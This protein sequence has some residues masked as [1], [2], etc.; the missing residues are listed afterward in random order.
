MVDGAPNFLN[1]ILRIKFI[2][3]TLHLYPQLCCMRL[4]QLVLVFVFLCVCLFFSSA[5]LLTGAPGGTK[6]FLS[7]SVFFLCV[8]VCSRT[9]GLPPPDCS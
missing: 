2:S 1:E 7:G 8:Y 9:G 5:C 4:P 6:A 3:I